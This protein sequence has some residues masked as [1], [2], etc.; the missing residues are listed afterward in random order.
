MPPFDVRDYKWPCREKYLEE[1][2]LFSAWMIFGNRADN[3]VDVTD[4]AMGNSDIMIGV[5]AD[6][7]EKI[8]EARRE[9]SQKLIAIMNGDA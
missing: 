3:T 9:F 8:I 2:P 7:A 6:K 1:N 5:P 4:C